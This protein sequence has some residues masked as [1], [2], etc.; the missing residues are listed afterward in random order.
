[1]RKNARWYHWPSFTAFYLAELATLVTY[2]LL[3]MDSAAAKAAVLGFIQ[4]IMYRKSLSGKM[5]W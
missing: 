2:K 3:R 1:M 4:G 5:P